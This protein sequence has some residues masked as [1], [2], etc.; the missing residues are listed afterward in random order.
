VSE[1][2]YCKDL[3]R[4]PR[5]FC[6]VWQHQSVITGHLWPCHRAA[7]NRERKGDEG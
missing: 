1:C 7:P 4:F 3:R 2:F 6:N 5:F